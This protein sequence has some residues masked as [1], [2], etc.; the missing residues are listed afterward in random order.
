MGIE[1]SALGK[2]GW[3]PGRQASVRGLQG[4]VRDFFFK[5]IFWVRGIW[6]LFRLEGVCTCIALSLRLP[7]CCSVLDRTGP[8]CTARVVSDIQ[9]KA[10][11]MLTEALRVPSPRA[12][13]C[14]WQG[15]SRTRPLLHTQ[16]QFSPGEWEVSQFAN[17]K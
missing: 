1:R 11:M 2:G 7:H 17:M 9:I 16:G 12:P 10:H 14:A 15:S 13:L 4:L 8:L 5:V 6:I 3:K